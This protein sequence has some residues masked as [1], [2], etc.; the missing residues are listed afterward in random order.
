MMLLTKKDRA[1]LPQLYSQDENPDPR[2]WIKFFCPWNDWVWLATE[3]SG[4]GYVEHDLAQRD[5][6]L[7]SNT[8][9]A[10][11]AEVEVLCRHWQS[12]RPRVLPFLVGTT[13]LAGP[14]G[15][16]YV[17]DDFKFFGYVHGHFDELGN[18]TLKELK[19]VHGPGIWSALGIERD[20]HFRP[21]PLSKVLADYTKSRGWRPTWSPRAT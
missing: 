2:V 10:T 3:G 11:D 18:F 5:N 8:R 15:T 17:L 7:E 19:S 1:K 14:P 12:S 13:V 16:Q 6:I 9:E 4:V 21:A 20:M